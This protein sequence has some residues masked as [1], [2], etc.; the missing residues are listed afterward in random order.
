MILRRLLLIALLA[1]VAAPQPLL[2]K[3]PPKQAARKAPAKKPAAKPAPAAPKAPG[4]FMV[5]KAVVLRNP[6]PA[7]VEANA[8]WNLRAALNVAALQCQ[9]S[10]F[11]QT[12]NNY[13]AFLRHHSE[14]LVAAQ[15]VMM[16]H[17]RRLDGAR[18]ATSFD[19]YTTR[20][21]NSYSTLDAQYNFCIAA[22]DVGRRVL[23]IPQG[24]LGQYARAKGPQIR[25]SLNQRPL[26]PM[27][28][29]QPIAVIAMPPIPPL[30]PAAP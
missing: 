16:G 11:L 21:Y 9:F 1:C 4:G 13:N 15:S 10:K 7:E 2:A 25:E 5:P 22:G 28:A 14:E 23:A 30:D 29:I 3:V 24:Q 18:A 27:L 26:T 20:T 8:V 19:Q 12:V 17:F 6:T